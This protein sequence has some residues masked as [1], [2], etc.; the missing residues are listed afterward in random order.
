MRQCEKEIEL[1]LEGTFLITLGCESW[2]LT[3]GRGKMLQEIKIE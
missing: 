3:D 2:V 1:W